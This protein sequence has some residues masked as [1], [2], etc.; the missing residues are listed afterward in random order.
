MEGEQEG[1][2]VDF[3]KL[4][5]HFE[6]EAPFYLTWLYWTCDEDCEYRCMR[7]HTLLCHQQG[8]RPL[9]FRGKWPFIR[10]FGIQEFFSVVASF[11]N[12]LGPLAGLF[13]CLQK[14]PNFFLKNIILGISCGGILAWTSSTLFHTR[15]FYI[16]ERADY[17]SADVYAFLLS[18]YSIIRIWKLNYFSSTLLLTYF[19]ILFLN[20]VRYMQFS[21]FDYGYNTLVATFHFGLVSASWIYF[22]VYYW[23]KRNY[24][25][26]IIPCFLFTWCGALLE[27]L[28]F[29]P[30]FDLIDAHALWHFS[31]IP[32]SY[33]FLQIIIEDAITCWNK[34]WKKLS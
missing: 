11:L 24:A 21:L 8:K 5:N 10:I 6:K 22:S 7:N 19:G 20:H 14:V 3:T 27:I 17:Y 4:Q 13:S 12:L 32:M 9:Q 25:K 26:K 33:F 2:F 23:K 30:L 29:A 18:C 31:S 28:D 1:Q 34:G 15:D 16:T